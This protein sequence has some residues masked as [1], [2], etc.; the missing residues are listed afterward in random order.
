[1]DEWCG[2]YAMKRSELWKEYMTQNC[3]IYM[4]SEWLTTRERSRLNKKIS[5]H[6]QTTGGKAT[7]TQNLNWTQK[8]K[9]TTTILSRITFIKSD[10]VK[11]G[12]G[13][14]EEY[15]SK[16]KR[17]HQHSDSRV[18]NKK[19]E[20]ARGRRKKSRMECWRNKSSKQQ[21]KKNTKITST[22]GNNLSNLPKQNWSQCCKKN[23]NNEERQQERRWRKKDD[24]F[25]HTHN[26]G[27]RLS[28]SPF[29]ECIVGLTVTNCWWKQVMA[30]HN[31]HQRLTQ[32]T[33]N[34]HTLNL[35]CHTPFGS[36]MFNAQC[37]LQLFNFFR[38]KHKA[39]LL[40]L[41]C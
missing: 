26:S 9:S 37:P 35:H 16:Y 14:N 38:L 17:Q 1:M 34:T 21:E 24:T 22:I 2:F 39:R 11:N 18:K 28:Q 4:C 12:Y 25:T 31:G 15:F 27:H 30:Q 23:N 41:L 29:M 40:G 20:R 13:Q 8:K 36:L 32:A 33:H 6:L 10:W 5:T 7:M 19:Q 3:N